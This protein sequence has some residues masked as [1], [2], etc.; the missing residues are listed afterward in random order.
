MEVLERVFN[1]C[2]YQITLINR[3]LERVVGDKYDCIK[4]SLG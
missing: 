3:T 2:I 4:K 1:K